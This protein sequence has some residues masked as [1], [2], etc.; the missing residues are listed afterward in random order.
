MKIIK[1]GQEARNALKRGIDIVCDDVK[2]SA[3]PSGL[4]AVIGR[5]DIPPIIT[6]DGVSI[7]RNSESNDEIE[8]QGCWIV[9]EAL[10]V[11]SNKVGDGTTTTAILLQAI[12]KELFEKL[13]DNGSLVVKKPDAIK[14]MK[15]VDTACEVI[16]TELKK[17][18]RP[19]TLEEVYNVALSAGEFDW[20]A[21]MVSEVFSKIGKDGYVKV[22]EGVKTSYETFKGIEINSGYPS[23]YFQNK[24]D[25]CIL[26]NPCILVT[27]QK[28][29]V[30]AAVKVIQ[31]VSGKDDIGGVI[32]VAPEYTADLIS[33]L[34]TTKTKTGFSCV[35]LKVQTYDKNDL[36]LD[37]ATLTNA[38]FLDKNLYTKYEDFVADITFDKLG[39]FQEAE[40]SG[41]KSIFKGGEGD[42][43]ERIEKIKKLREESDSIFDK[44]E[45]DRRIAYLSG[46]MAAVKIGGE[47][48]FERTYFKLKA[49]NAFAS[50]QVALR[51]GVVKGGGLAL[52][53]VSDILDENILTMAIRAP[54]N[55][56]QSNTGGITIGDNIID[57]VSVTISSLKSACSIAG[58]V[59]TTEVVIA[60]KN[61][62]PD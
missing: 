3:G 49:D 27:N 23:E 61:E 32:L 9:K 57:P 33:R 60:F 16:V 21:K 50:A 4:N 13:D 45:Y 2:I 56:I 28:M 24:G 19:I 25:K 15:E 58:R 53:D 26:E 22:E 44:D 42:T 14:L 35:A 47:S 51:D 18:S 30:T 36:L 43:T 7:A 6:N 39:K 41:N 11:A 29:D 12:V 48:D 40:I 10:S 38:K 17:Q 8:N 55:Q 20:L 31:G 62:D 1:R 37:I 5:V 46:G 54:Y 59:I 52:K 34:N